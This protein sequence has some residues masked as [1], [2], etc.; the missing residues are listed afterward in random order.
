MIQKEKPVRKLIVVAGLSSMLL[1]AVSGASAKAAPASKSGSGAIVIVFKDGHRQTFNLADIVRVEFPASASASEETGSTNPLAPPRGRF[2]GKWEVG[3]G[4]GDN[5][6]I[7]LKENGD[8]YRSLG[9]QRG[10]WEYVNGEAQVTWDDG[11]HDAIRKVGSRFQKFAYGSGKSFTDVPDN[12][13][14]AHNT[15]PRP[16]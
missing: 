4:N 12:V 1:L 9:N 5:F 13:A 10:K 14:D 6:I 11:A 8:A 15:S 3:E 16:I 2:L 7:T